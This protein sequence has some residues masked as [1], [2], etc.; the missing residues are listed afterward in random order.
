MN[1][2]TW[3]L[4]GVAA[5]AIVGLLFASPADVTPTVTVKTAGVTV[6]ASPSIVNVDA[7]GAGAKGATTT[8]P[9]GTPTASGTA[10]GLDMPIAR[11]AIYALS[12]IAV[13]LLLQVIKA[14]FAIT[15]M[16]M[17]YTT[18]AVCTG[19]GAGLTAL[20]KDGSISAIVAN[21]WN[22]LSGAG[23]VFTAAYL[24]YKLLIKRQ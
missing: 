22:V 19:T 2:N 17:V 7:T 10:K 21:P 24:A 1:T 13:T 14:K 23:I 5:L 3:I 20:F 12:G 16:K 18:L 15:G 9:G 11:Y 8:P 6:V 4:V